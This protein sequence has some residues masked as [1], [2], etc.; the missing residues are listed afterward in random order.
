MYSKQSTK[1]LQKLT[2]ELLKKM[3]AGS[4]AKKDL[5]S[6]RV[7]LRFHEYRYYI[8]NDPLLADYE[9]DQL[10]KNLEKIETENPDLITADSPTQ[11]VAK[12]LTKDFP[13]AQHLVPMLSLDNSYNN[14]DL[15]DFDRKAREL[16]GL[17]EI[18]YCVE[19]KFDGGSISLIYEDDFLVRGATRGDGVEGDEVTT[20]I[21]QIR[22]LPLSAR[23]S[24]YGL[25]QVEIR[26]E[27]LINKTNFARY[28]NQLIEQGI[29]PLA[30][31]RNAAAGTLRI[32][33][34]TEV[35]KRNLEAFVYHVSYFTLAKGKKVPAEL[36][37]HSGSLEM[38]WELG[39]RSPQ[40]E[41]KVLKGIQKVIDYCNEYEIKRDGLPYEIDGM[42]IK[43]NETSL[44]DKMGMTSHHPR[45]AIAFKFKARQATSKL[46][47][48]EFQVGRTGSITPVAKI[49]P[50]P[51]GGVTVS[52][53]SL[54]NEDVIKEKDLKI[55]D[56][57]LVER[58]GD[59]IP[60]IVKSLAELRTGTEKKIHFPKHCPVCESKLF[61][62]EGEAVWRCTNIDCPAQV[63][64]RII[65]FVSKDAMDIRGFGEANVRKFY[66][67]G[68][69]KDI[70]GIYTLDF[71]KIGKLEGFGTRSIE[72]LQA[73][74]QQ[75]KK[76]PLHRLIFALG[77]RFVGETTAKT[78][79]QA[80]NHLLDFRKFSEDDLKNLEDVGPK[81]AGSIYHFF[82]NKNNLEMLEELEKLGLQLKNTKKELASGGNL[83]GLSFLFTG[84]LPT[85]KRSDAEAIVESNGGHILG[86]VSAKLNYLV[87][88]EDAG[89]KLEKAKKIN[90]VKIISEA[91]FLKMTGQK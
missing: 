56:T 10:Y 88:G 84:T 73:A 81:V 9:Y 35:A 90:T 36:T 50:V 66:E 55:G 68:L 15:V 30:N 48:V 58:A 23:F 43:V 1:D 70:P 29:P 52:S 7:V 4:I 86:G 51:I 76:Q 13:S 85:L 38:L 59:V 54:F 24:A 37:T 78:L 44:Q 8:L 17:K 41:K 28:N 6:L 57:V 22:S 33:D 71:E 45:W 62:E 72:N 46:L 31:P 5:D 91:E 12:G 34:P 63:A 67:L 47:N 80:V 20:N 18:E 32:K 64:E 60:Y 40:Q 11:R 53:I 25:Q 77:I 87:V 42:V 69:L 2:A 83:Q 3:A 39:F 19:P 74:I 82:R 79:A 21:K 75:S 26:G 16:T 65:H 61:K 89:S 49:Q 14:A 27:V